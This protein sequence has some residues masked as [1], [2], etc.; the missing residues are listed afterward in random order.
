MSN[1][2]IHAYNVGFGDAI[3]IRVPR[4]RGAKAFRDILIDGGNSLMGGGGNDD[5]LLMAM[6]DIHRKTGGTLDLYVLTHEHMDHV[7]GP[8]LLKDKKNLTFKADRVWATPSSG[9]DY[10]QKFQEAKEKKRRALAMM[11]AMERQ[12]LH[13]S[14]DD[15]GSLEFVMGLNNPRKTQD[16]VDHI[17]G[18][19]PRSKRRVHYVHADMKKR[20]LGRILDFSG[21]DVEVWAPEENTA[22][23]YGR[24]RPLALAGAF[25]AA[26][27]QPGGAAQP[28][29]PPGVS[30]ADFYRLTRSR[31]GGFFGNALM[32]DKATNN[33]SVVLL[34]TWK[35]KRLL[36]AGDAEERSWRHIQKRKLVAPVDFLKISH[37]GSHNGTPD[38]IFKHLLVDGRNGATAKTLISTIE[39]QHSGV[40]FEDLMKEFRDHTDLTDT[41]AAAPGR[42]VVVEIE[43]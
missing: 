18:E 30:M 28:V 4:H 15:S 26:A 23:Y 7:Q 3:L 8:L 36:F 2:E 29:P 31:E 12:M 43:P 33:T 35:G 16:C 34:I 21:I 20:D 37:H 10:Y 40:P 11:Q 9:P 42:A 27:A 24:F 14:A 19:I 38:E 41:R 6:E 22:D 13:F 5:D 32:I 25:G 1:L 39:D 17:L